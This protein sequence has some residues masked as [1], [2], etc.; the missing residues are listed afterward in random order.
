MLKCWINFWLFKIELRN[1]LPQLL[2]LQCLNHVCSASEIKR[3]VLNTEKLLRNQIKN[4]SQIKTEL[5]DNHEIE[6]SLLSSQ[7]YKFHSEFT[8]PISADSEDKFDFD[9]H[10]H[11]ALKRSRKS[12]K[13]LVAR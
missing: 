4:E 11:K 6:F 12:A 3:K 10:I 9:G 8:N 5:D 1:H 13:K 2:C 7:E